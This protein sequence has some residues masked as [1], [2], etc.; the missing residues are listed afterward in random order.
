MSRVLS[1]VIRPMLE[2]GMQ[3]CY[4]GLPI[5]EERFIGINMLNIYFIDELPFSDKRPVG[6]VL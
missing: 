4:A 2:P 5:E 1:E 6:H 3:M